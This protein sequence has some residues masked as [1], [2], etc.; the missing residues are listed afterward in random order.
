MNKTSFGQTFCGEYYGVL[1]KTRA[2]RVQLA[3]FYGADSQ[4][5]YNG[6]E[7][8]GLQAVCRHIESL[9]FEKIIYK[10]DNMDIIERPGQYTIL[11]QGAL[12]MDDSEEFRFTQN[13]NVVSNGNNGFYIQTDIL[14]LV[15]WCEWR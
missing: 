1:M 8:Q 3:S 13:F 14:A 4:M 2:E 5:I 15:L 12:R 6:T 10:I 11:I 7:C 9:G